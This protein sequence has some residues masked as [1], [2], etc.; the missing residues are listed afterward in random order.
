LT[1]KRFI[2]SIPLDELR[3]EIDIFCELFA[4]SAVQ[5]G[6]KRFV[7]SRDAQPYLP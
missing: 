6:L 2:K 4:R 3:K 7:E 5:A 1:A